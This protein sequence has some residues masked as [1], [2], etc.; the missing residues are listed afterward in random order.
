MTFLPTAAYFLAAILL[1]YSCVQFYEGDKRISKT[2]YWIIPIILT[3]GV[4]LTFGRSTLM[5]SEAEYIASQETDESVQE[6]Y[7]HY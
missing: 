6:R 3:S 2:H 5:E 4:F 1:L 7:A